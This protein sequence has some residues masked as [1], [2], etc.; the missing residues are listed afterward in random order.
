METFKQCTR[1]TVSKSTHCHSSANW[2]HSEGLRRDHP[3]CLVL[4]E[5]H[6]CLLVVV[7]RLL[8]QQRS[9]GVIQPGGEHKFC[10]DVRLGKNDRKLLGLP[11]GE[12]VVRNAGGPLRPGFVRLEQEDP[13]EATLVD[14]VLVRINFVFVGPV[15]SGHNGGS[16]YDG[17]GFE[18]ADIVHSL[19]PAVDVFP[20]ELDYRRPSPEHKTR[21][22]LG[23]LALV[24]KKANVVG[25]GRQVLMIHFGLRMLINNA[26]GG[27]GDLREH[28]LVVVGVQ[29][30]VKVALVNA[31]EVH[32]AHLKNHR[33]VG[34][35]CHLRVPRVWKLR[36]KLLPPLLNG[37][38]VQQLDRPQLLDHIAVVFVTTPCDGIV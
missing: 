30:S 38:S 13:V 20:K 24:R 25:F 11:N 9:K 31:L 3:L 5:E 35:C 27:I 36:E 18:P 7:V 2:S 14:R 16:H 32:P 1:P 37:H 26:A 33:P 21:A 12:H 34:L 19:Y 28:R 23:A 15:H 17:I 22:L 4:V 10:F 6:Q 8:Q 29:N